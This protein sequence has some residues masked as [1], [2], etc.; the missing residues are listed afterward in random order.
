MMSS[1]SRQIESEDDN[2]S[3]CEEVKQQHFITIE[4]SPSSSGSK[5]PLS[6][7]PSSNTLTSST[8]TAES[9]LQRPTSGGKLIQNRTEANLSRANVTGK[10]TPPARSGRVNIGSV[11]GGDVGEEVDGGGV[12]C[13]VQD[14][15][16]CM[17][18]R[19]NLFVDG[20]LVHVGVCV[21]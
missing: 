14:N 5:P 8:T 13:M 3:P 2:I 15:D 7:L 16:D 6:F 21:L 11:G 18:G 12:E 1:T 20:C 10:D 19:K 17:I 9:R 4:P